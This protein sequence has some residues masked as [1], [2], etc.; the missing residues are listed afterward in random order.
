[1]IMLNLQSIEI[2][3]HYIWNSCTDQF[4][5]HVSIFGVFYTLL[6]LSCD[7]DKASYELFYDII[8]SI[9]FRHVDD[10]GGRTHE[11]QQSAVKCMRGILF[12][13]M[14]QAHKV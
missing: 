11:L 3:Q 7:T 8:K 5:N 13:Y 1:M 12:F 2:F 9:S 10:D 6:A 14:R 4:L